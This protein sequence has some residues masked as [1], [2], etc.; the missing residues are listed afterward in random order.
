V[1]TDQQDHFNGHGEF[2]GLL[3]RRR[4]A[5][6]L[7]Q[8]QLAERAGLSVRTIRDLERG[9]TTRPYR[10]S[11]G[12]L[13]DALG[14]AGAD[15][16]EFT[17]IGR[18]AREGA[19][20]SGAGQRGAG[21]R[22]AG[23]GAAGQGAVGQP[24]D[25]PVPRHLP[26][27]TAGFTG[28]TGELST[29]TGLLET[30][31][32]P[33]TMVIS[34]IGGTAG[35]GK[36][37]LA[38]HW[39]HRVAGRFP[40]GQL[41]VNLRGY[42]PGQ[43]LAPADALAGFLRALGVPGQDIPPGAGER[44]ARYRGLLAGRRMLVLLDNASSAEQVRPLLPATPGCVTVVTS[45]DTLAGLIARDGARRLDLDLLPAADANQLLVTLIGDRAAADP[46]ATGAL[47]TACARL[48]L[49][50]RVAAELA[51][52]R[53]GTPVAGLV[54]ELAGER[55]RLDLLEAGG[56]PRTA[57]RAVFSWSCRRLD[58]D[59]A[60]MFRLA[61]LHPSPGLDGYAA[62][63]LAGT[64]AAAAT[65]LLGQ[66]ARAH[67]ITA[68]GPGR[69]GMHDLLR[70][71]AAEL[72]ARHDGEDACRAALT[73]LFDHYLHTAA[74]AMDTLQP[75]E[76]HR[77]PRVPAPGTPVPPVR[78]PAGAAA[79]LAAS[80]PTLVEVVAYAAGHGWPQHATRLAATLSRYLDTGG[81][82][83]E[84][85]TVH[86]SARRAAHQAGDLAGEADALTG[87]GIIDWTQ[88]RYQRA[89]DQ[90]RRAL[91]LYQD[92]GDRAG[93]ARALNNI[94]IAD[95]SQGHHQEASR[96]FR[97]ALALYRASG[98]RTGEARALTNLGVARRNEGQYTDA[99]EH[100]RRALDLHRAAGSRSGEAETLTEL[101]GVE[102]CEGRHGEAAGHFGQA[103]SLF[104]ETGAEA[105]AA[106]ALNGLG[107]AFLAAG[108]PG[109]ASA[110][111]AAALTLA[112]QAADKREQARAH[113][114][115]G[116]AH[117]ALGD[118][119]RAG[120]HWHQALALYADLGADEASEVRA[121]LTGLEEAR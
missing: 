18:P 81:H 95:G 85:I 64:G 14:L 80:L 44:A 1:N 11:V 3:R 116:Q 24:P 106:Y 68:T 105:R 49:A 74:T 101:G 35:V 109:Q 10:S 114:G 117:Q 47:A 36:T 46:E 33:G 83:S 72:A 2:S 41:Y 7:T 16:A 110:Q 29:L 103:L 121:R 71:Y 99:T 21:Q 84:A 37:A 28:R 9:A 89:A 104:R 76:R 4:I 86:T 54:A 30:G 77:R 5:V 108:Q 42:D 115:L 50:L 56:D 93:E 17:G 63:A 61:G 97:R 25:R 65:R 45:R 20:Q 69:L 79:W 92:A 12:K 22:G 43:P 67:L 32:P 26:A 66:L 98:D 38:L 100:L 88:G 111:H 75:A 87:L 70:D 27:A 55:R 112:S 58:E 73:R 52:A 57:V 6:G 90:F 15:R 19:G 102:L 13:A 94:G 53:P 23:Q 91:A 59:A 34:A 78:D 40:D 120:Q 113:D 96:H 62:A 8:E 118:P 31:S 107:G 119:G 39:A 82:V 51:A 60:R 48:P